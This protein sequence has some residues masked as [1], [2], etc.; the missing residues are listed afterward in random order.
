[1][2]ENV[3]TIKFNSKYVSGTAKELITNFERNTY[4]IKGSTGV[5][6]TTALLNYTESHCL[7][8]SPNVGMIKGKEGKQYTSD[9]QVFIYASSKDKWKDVGDYLDNEDNNNLIINTTPDQICIIRNTNKELYDKLRTFNVFVDEFHVYTTDATFRDS[10]GQLMEII[11]NEW[12]AKFKLSTATPNYNLFDIP[13]N[14]NIDIYKIERADQ[15]KKKLAYSYDINDVKPFIYDEVAQGR[16]VVLFTNN[17]RYHKSFKD[18]KVHN[19]TGE[20]LKVKLAPFERGQDGINFASDTQVLIVSSSY[21]AGF[22]ID[23]DCSM[24]FVSEE[25]MP[26]NKININNLMQA[27][28]RGR[29]NIHNAL[30]IN[31]RAFKNQP[32]IVT[33]LNDVNKAIAI[34]ERSI[35]EATENLEQ[36]TGYSLNALYVNRSQCR[37]EAIQVANDYVQYTPSLMVKTLKSNNFEVVEYDNTYVNDIV[38]QSTT[39]LFQERIK[40]LLQLDEKSLVYSYLTIKKNLTY[41]DN[42]SFTT[43]LALEYLTSILIKKSDTNL[44]SMLDNKRLKANE[45]YGS[46]NLFLRV[47]HPTTYLYEQLTD[48]QQRKAESLHKQEKYN[49]KLSG[50]WLLI[51][52]WYLLYAVHKAKK[53]TLPTNIEREILIYKYFYDEDIYNANTSDKKNRIRTTTTHIV[54]QIKDAKVVLNDTE[55]I[56]LN[57][58]IKNRYKTLDSGETLT[59]TNTKE[60]LVKKMVHALLFLWSG[61]KNEVVKEVKN[62]EYHSITQLPSAFRC[63]VP[64]KYLSVD[65]TS[66]NPQIVDSILN[67]GLAMDVYKNLMNKRNITRN[68][69]KKM[70]NSCLNN[71]KLTLT[72]AYEIYL[73]AGYGEMKS[74]ELSKLT[75]QV[76]KGSFYEVMTRNE[77]KLIDNY[78][79]ILPIKNYRF[80]DA[81]IMEYEDVLNYNITLPNYVNDYV[82]H[83]DFFNDASDYTNVTNEKVLSTNG[84]VPNHKV[85]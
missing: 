54:K 11:F 47:N 25:L 10:V 35:N 59:N 21:Y 48:V 58:V 53:G 24:I 18:L 41:K 16:M 63:I 73:D 4:I 19:L 60:H 15:P 23:V 42:P 72:K 43:S 12:I 67:T 84:F 40:N 1:M 65:L 64:I 78:S 29:A 49:E 30:Y 70:Y 75:A 3:K 82:Y 32:N 9:R 56:W 8:I 62:R 20:T 45:L 80:H 61:G 57:N 38:I 74:K 39:T 13:K 55:I 51:K 6:G 68:E 71:H 34:A 77:K 52:E 36:N 79:S 85:A 83:T 2:L 46:F 27:Y 81:I 50:S 7:I 5:G 33:T 37:A 14:I 44:V 69:A 66:A 17:S 76:P 26:Q 22:D 28:G 31:A